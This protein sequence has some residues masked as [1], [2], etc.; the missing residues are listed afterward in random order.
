MQMTRCLIRQALAS[1]VPVAALISCNTCVHGMP[2]LQLKTTVN[3][4]LQELLE[5]DFGALEKRLEEYTRKNRED[6]IARHGHDPY[7]SMKSKMPERLKWDAKWFNDDGTLD[8][9]AAEALKKWEADTQQAL[10]EATAASDA[11]AARLRQRYPDYPGGTIPSRKD[12]LMSRQPGALTASSSS[13]P[14]T[15]LPFYANPE[16]SQEVRETL[17]HADT[18]IEMS[19]RQNELLENLMEPGNR[20]KYK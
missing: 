20:G 18:I 7:E 10:E 19:K 12:L 17:A 3:S 1:F 9:E 2:R 8:P 13:Q 14:L 4:L 11:A 15:E 5:F 6:R 16:L